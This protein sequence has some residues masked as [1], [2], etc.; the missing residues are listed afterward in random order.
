M[1]AIREVL[2]A[3]NQAPGVKGSAVVTGD[4]ITVATE[5]GPSLDCDVVAGLVSF[6]ISTAR[7]S[8]HE[9]ELGT[10]TR[11]TMHS[12]NGKIVLVSLGDA[13]LIIYTDQFADLSRLQARFEDATAELRRLVQVNV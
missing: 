12:T 7:R 2:T 1:S 6:L 8:L 9:G 4:G 10:M 11:F 3:L 13:F 5:L